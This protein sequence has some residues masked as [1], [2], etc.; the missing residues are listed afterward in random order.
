MASGAHG[1]DLVTGGSHFGYSSKEGLTG[2]PEVSV[3]GGQAQ[4]PRRASEGSKLFWEERG[5]HVRG[6]FGRGLGG[7]GWV[8]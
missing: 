7:L 6:K 4:S 2:L 5:R 8:C 1:G 3:G